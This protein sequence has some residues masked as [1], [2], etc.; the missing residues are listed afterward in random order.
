MNIS[1][2]KTV[3]FDCDGVILQ[4]NKIKTNAFRDALIDE[5]ND[6]VDKFIS[7]HQDNGGISRY[8]KFEHYYRNI[9]HEKQYLLMSKK[10]ISRYAKIV[11]DQLMEVQYVPG[12]LDIINYL[13]INKTP[14]FV[15]S[16]G[17]QDE[18]H[19]IFKHREI[20]NNFIGI[21]GS[22]VSKNDHIKTL[23]KGNKLN[24]PIIL[25][26]D[27]HS[28]M[29]AALDNNIDFCFVSQFSEWNHGELLVKEFMCD[30]I[31]NFEELIL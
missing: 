6:L 28:D 13:N 30:T 23:V 2:Y 25:F 4:S 26:G 12:F 19:K 3:I 8:V 10:A 31:N 20:F 27:A 14:C 11:L 9:K 15:V 24:Y 17:D 1:K 21:F 5:P 29:G 18:F 16:G 7:Y 22:P